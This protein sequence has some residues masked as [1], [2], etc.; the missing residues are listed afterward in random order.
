M[1]FKF[2]KNN[3]KLLSVIG[4]SILFLIFIFLENVLKCSLEK[5]NYFLINDK[6]L[7]IIKNLFQNFENDVLI[8]SDVLFFSEIFKENINYL[9]DYYLNTNSQYLKFSKN[10]LK[11]LKYKG[12]EFKKIVDEDLIKKVNSQFDSYKLNTFNIG[13]L[14]NFEKN[15]K[16]VF[17]LI[18][19][20]VLINLI[21]IGNLINQ[22]Y[23][24]NSFNDI[25]LEFY[26][27]IYPLEKP[28][29][30]EQAINEKIENLNLQE[31]K[32]LKLIYKISSSKLKNGRLV[33]LYYSR[34]L[35]KFE[36]EILFN[37]SSEEIIFLNEQ[38][39]EGNSFKKV[40]SRTDR[41]LVVTKFIYEI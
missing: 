33:D 27:D 7:K 17:G 22:T 12:S 24:L 1:K 10:A 3:K 21:G 40:S 41:G 38:A 37:N 8:T 15:K 25:I 28:L 18:S 34:E 16:Y 14:I 39:F 4:F 30:V 31:S 32:V 26:K 19:A 11:V 2:S 36:F 35:N 13:N 23:K 9:D 20:I 6:N 5:G 29:N